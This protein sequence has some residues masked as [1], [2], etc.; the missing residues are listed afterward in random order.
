M[1]KGSIASLGN[2]DWWGKIQSPNT[3]WCGKSRAPWRCT[4]STWTCWCT[5][6][7]PSFSSSHSTSPSTAGSGTSI[8]RCTRKL[9]LVYEL[10]YYVNF[11]KFRTYQQESARGQTSTSI[12]QRDIRLAQVNNMLQFGTSRG[13][14][15]TSIQQRDI[16]LAQVNNM[17]QFG[18]SRGQ[19]S[20]SIQQRDIRLAQVNNMLHVGDSFSAV[21]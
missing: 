5:A 4:S 12:Q 15:S 9:I 16:R 20:T 3:D 19:T 7:S 17:L 8:V 10:K 18:T 11:F 13:Q 1:D 21:I 6:W 14:T 2:L